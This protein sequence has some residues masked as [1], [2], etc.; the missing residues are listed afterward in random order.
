VRQL[1]RHAR[2]AGG[3]AGARAPRAGPSRRG[4]ARCRRRDCRAGRGGARRIP[5]AEP[6]LSESDGRLFASLKQLRSTIAREEQVPAYV[7][8]P[9]RTLAE[10]A[11]RRPRTLAA[12]EGVRGVGPAKLQKYGP[13]FLAVIHSTNDTEAA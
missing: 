4:C 12:M 1:P 2:R 8:F 3:E 6:E 10:M 7:V 11:V 9:D 5:P 13:R